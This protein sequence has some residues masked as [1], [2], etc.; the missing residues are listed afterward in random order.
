MNVIIYCGHWVET[1]AFYRDSLG[2]SP[3][4][5][6][7]W[8]VEF[9]VAS[10]TYLSVADAERTSIQ[11]S[12]GAGITITFKVADVHRIWHDLM[13]RNVMVDPIRDNCLGGQ[14]FFLHD[15]EGNRL[16]FWS[17]SLIT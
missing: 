5:V 1:V 17:E 8:L 11:L 4:R 7:D 12:G 15:P 14:A 16:E 2:L 9:E 13:G 6:A 10:N 3:K